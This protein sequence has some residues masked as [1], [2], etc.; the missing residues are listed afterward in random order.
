MYKIL[1]N[2]ITS[3]FIGNS[4]VYRT[5]SNI[6]FLFLLSILFLLNYK[7]LSLSLSLKKLKKDYFMVLQQ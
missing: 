1:H 7:F 4:F 6:Y 3:Q 2:K 5:F